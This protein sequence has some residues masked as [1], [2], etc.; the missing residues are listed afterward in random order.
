MKKKIIAALILL[1]V[2][3]SACGNE[4]ENK[5]SEPTAKQEAE[6][7]QDSTS[8]EESKEDQKEKE[9]KEKQEEKTFSTGE[10]WT[11][12]GQWSLTVNSISTTDQ[13]NEYEEKTPAQVFIVDYTYENLGYEDENGL[14]EGIFFDLS[15]GQ[16]IDSTGLMGYSYPGDVTYYAQEAPVGAKC[17]AQ[18]C[19]GVD[20]ESTELKITISQYDGTGTEQK[21]TF[22]LP[23]S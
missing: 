13:R 14:M 9:N 15:M 6:E 22:V 1:C 10:T 19:I 2:S 5:G 7:K 20:N 11:V 3:V 17:Q 12:D 21:A 8:G 16:I 18:A 23:I 4:T